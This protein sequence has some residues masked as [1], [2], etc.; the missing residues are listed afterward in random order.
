MSKS[1]WSWSAEE[2]ELLNSLVEQYGRK[3]EEIAT[4]FEGRT[5]NA[6][7]LRYYNMRSESKVKTGKFSA[8]ED[9]NLF[10]WIFSTI[11]AKLP[12]SISEFEGRR[13]GDLN[14]RVDQ[15]KSMFYSCLFPGWEFQQ[16]K[17]EEDQPK[18]K[19]GRPAGVKGVKRK[20]NRGGNDLKRE[21]NEEIGRIML[22][23]FD[24]KKEPEDRNKKEL[25]KYNDNEILNHN[26]TKR[27]YED[28]RLTREQFFELSG[29]SDEDEKP[30]TALEDTQLFELYNAVGS[31]WI[32][33]EKFINM[34]SKDEIRN[35]FY[36]TLKWAAFEY[37]DDVDKELNEL[38]NQFENLNNL[39]ID[40]PINA[41][42]QD[43]ENLIP[44]AVTLLKL[45]VSRKIL[46]IPP[47]VK[48]EFKE[49]SGPKT[50]ED[51]LLNLYHKS[52][53]KSNSSHTSPSKPSSK[54]G[55]NTQ[56]SNKEDDSSSASSVESD[57]SLILSKKQQFLRNAV[58]S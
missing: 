38:R 12:T 41:S 48:S 11:E 28:K 56:L 19:R 10:N 37:K 1:N 25:D 9:R 49:S 23:E 20:R 4:H 34:R 21:Y 32:D 45:D 46:W 6:C 13:K 5:H 53:K 2:D 43:L 15:L 31:K 3:W 42:E 54:V 39:Y 29:I 22:Q 44:V 30:W 51:N 17:K 57:I 58:N 16:F 36:N 7:C 40:D 18:G 55:K 26:E 47:S 27:G 35:H 14:K 50:K 24:I 52:I 8:E 33:F